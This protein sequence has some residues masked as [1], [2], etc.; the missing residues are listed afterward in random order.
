VAT[1]DELWAGTDDDVWVDI[2]DRT[3]VLDTPDHDDR[4]RNNREGYALW[5]PNLRR[6]HIKRILIRKG[7]DGFAGGWKL[8]AVRVWF[9]GTLICDQPRINKWL[10]DE[11]RVWVGCVS[12]RD[13][14]NSLE[15][16]VTT[17][18]VLWVGTDDDV[19]ITIA[20]RAWDLDN[21]WHDDFERGNTDSFVLDPGP[22]L[23][24]HNIHSIR[25]HKSRDGFAGGWRL[26]GVRLIANGTTVYNNQAINKWLEDDD[27]TWQDIF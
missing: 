9:E 14:V 21:P 5:D 2:G 24:I 26:K 16:R 17:A 15:V 11:D 7:P 12:D 23:Y 4:E 25:I 6:E 1:A 8:G 19:S 20:G 27:R 22:G 13:L 18:D 10:E 3:Y